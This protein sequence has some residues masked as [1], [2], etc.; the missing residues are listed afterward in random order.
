MEYGGGCG[1]GGGSCRVGGVVA[2]ITDTIQT[3]FRTQRTSFDGGARVLNNKAL[4]S[5][6]DDR[7]A[8][9]Y[10]YLCRWC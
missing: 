9:N 1:D 2:I 6:C 8:D 7:A 3:T 10:N 4:L 5:L